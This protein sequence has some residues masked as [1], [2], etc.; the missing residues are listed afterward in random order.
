[1]QYIVKINV[2]NVTICA[3]SDK[4]AADALAKARRNLAMIA[5]R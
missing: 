2:A 5:P 3:K 1:M 4:S